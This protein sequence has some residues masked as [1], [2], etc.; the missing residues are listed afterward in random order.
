[1]TNGPHNAAASLY[2]TLPRV[3]RD[4]DIPRDGAEPHLRAYLDALG[5]VLDR[6]RATLR[7]RYDD[8]FPDTSVPGS[9]CQDWVIPYF[10]DLFAVVLR[11]PYPDGQRNEVANAV[12]WAQRKGTLQT[13]EEVIEAILQTEAEVQE[14]WR[15][16]ATTARIGL[17]LP[18]ALSTGA[19]MPVPPDAA[20]AGPDATAAE[21]ARHPALPALTPDMRRSSRAVKADEGTPSAH[22]TRFGR[23][24]PN[25]PLD[26]LSTPADPPPYVFWR[27]ANPLGAPCF[28]GSY[29]DVWRRTP[30][31]RDS[32]R[33]RDPGQGHGRYHPDRLLIHIPPPHGLCP[34]D[35]VELTWAEVQSPVPG[36]PSGDHIERIDDPDTGSTTFR[37]ITAA[38]VQ[39]SDP[40]ILTGQPA[41]HFEKL[42]LAAGVTVGAD[43]VSFRRCAVSAITAAGPGGQIA[44]TDCLAD[45]ITASQRTLRAEFVTV[46]SACDAQLL[47]ASDCIFAGT[48]D[49]ALNPDDCVRF[50]RV[51][52]AAQENALTT[53]HPVFRSAVFGD[54]GCGVLSH[55]T[56]RA[57]THGAEDGGEMGAYH[58][59]R[60]LARF[61]ALAAKLADYL[62]VGITPAIDDDPRLL[63]RPPSPSP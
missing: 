13:V 5:P 61:D 43:A 50:S 15:R 54:P 28:P 52:Q 47:L 32:E 39:I 1:M 23:T 38:S 34:P 42:R 58:A 45:T 19:P 21:I 53:D 55:A 46:L 33:G 48:I 18:T 62:P 51:P 60:Y 17:P 30:D 26:D 49:N 24:A 29:E 16:V 25:W 22:R 27:Q 12:R 57:I 56:S 7:Q 8:S 9:R 10:A 20:Y 63:C 59:W 44:L 41:V 40:V 36:T 31:L 2:D 11:S 37:N 6:T 14:G 35:P 4:R 3:Y